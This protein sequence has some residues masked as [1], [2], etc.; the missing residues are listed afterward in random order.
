MEICII[1]YDVESFNI[2]VEMFVFVV[3]IVCEGDFK[4]IEYIF[5][6]L[7]NKFLVI[8]MKGFGMVVDLVL[9]YLEKYVL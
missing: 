4:I 2:I 9:E 3:I 8:I 7:E 6:V 5:W 1:D